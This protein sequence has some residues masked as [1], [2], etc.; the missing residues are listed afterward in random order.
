MVK[1]INGTFTQTQ[2]QPF[3]LPAEMTNR[4]GL[5]KN[6]R[7]LG[8][9][10]NSTTLLSYIEN[11]N[12]LDTVLNFLGNLSSSILPQPSVVMVISLVLSEGK[13]RHSDTVSSIFKKSHN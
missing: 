12:A 13:K 5:V 8:N 11:Y 4:P 1:K 9:N 2:R 6:I 3:V 10:A 7:A